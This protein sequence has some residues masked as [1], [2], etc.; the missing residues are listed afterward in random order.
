MM[1]QQEL[2][3][4]IMQ[5]GF[6][7]ENE[8]LN[9]YSLYYFAIIYEA[10]LQQNITPRKI[11][12]ADIEAFNEPFLQALD[13]I[14]EKDNYEPLHELIEQVNLQEFIIAELEAEDEDGSTLDDE[15]KTQLFVVSSGII[16][17]LNEA[18]S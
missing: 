12:E 1:S 10:F 15:I 8:D 2:V 11:T 7:Y 13:A 4:H 9:M 18:T 14:H 6:E 17:L 16:G 5:A 3:D